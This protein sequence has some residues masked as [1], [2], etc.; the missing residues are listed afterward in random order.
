MFKLK[1]RISTNFTLMFLAMAVATIGLLFDIGRNF[2]YL[3]GWLE[4][5]SDEFLASVGSLNFPIHF[6]T[7][8]KEAPLVSLYSAIYR[9]PLFGA[10]L[11]GVFQLRRL[12]VAVET[13][14]ELFTKKHILQLK[15]V[16]RVVIFS[17]LLF[18]IL[19]TVSGMLLWGHFL[20]SLMDIYDAAIFSFNVG[21]FFLFMLVG[22]IFEGVVLIFEQAIQL[23]EDND[24]I[25]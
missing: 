4:P 18:F 10:I 25:I 21:S 12:A 8:S 14:Q 20:D 9:L 2:S 22:A 3:V 17:G 23:Q 16:F 6:L 11:Y 15:K 24:S 5:S 19:Q 1:M 13:K 7:D